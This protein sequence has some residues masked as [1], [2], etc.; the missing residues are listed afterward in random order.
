YLFGRSNGALL[1]AIEVGHHPALQL[2][3]D[4]QQ[5]LA[6]AQRGMQDAVAAKE[7]DKLQET[8]ALRDAFLKELDEARGNPVVPHGELDQQRTAFQD[9][10][11]LARATTQ[12]MIAG[13]HGEGL[14]VALE[15][16]RT[17]YTAIKKSLET[18]T[19]KNQQDMA[20]AF[21][22]ARDNQTKT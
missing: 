8:D 21:A 19:S 9:Y 20:L 10:Y 7:A 3:R 5:I 15:S 17:K 11:Q 18:T 13:E 22:S 14:L 12:R 4:L 2:S 1:Q 6:D 16:M